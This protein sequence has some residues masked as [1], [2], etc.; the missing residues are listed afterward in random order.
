MPGIRLDPDQKVAIA[1]ALAAAGFHSI[2]AGFPAAAPE[3]VEAVRRIVAEVRGPIITALCRTLPSDIDVA[4]E[5]LADGMIHKRGVSLFVGT[6]P[7]HRKHTHRKSKT[8]IVRMTVEAIAHARSRRIAIV[9]FGP[10]DASRTEPDFLHEIYREAIAAG[11]TTVG[12]S[13]TVG[14]L[15]PDKAAD[16]IKAIQDAV[17]NIDR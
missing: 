4:A 12:F 2:D 1:R 13:D 6:S 7:Q 10:E 3:E 15:T 14:I 17:P 5:A 9:T 8:A 11:A 16:R